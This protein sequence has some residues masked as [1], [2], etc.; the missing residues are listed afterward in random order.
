MRLIKS[1]DNV[2]D[3][4]RSNLGKYKQK[5]MATPSRNTGDKDKK[6]KYIAKA[7]A[8]L[9]ALHANAKLEFN[10]LVFQYVFNNLRKRKT[11]KTIS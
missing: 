11:S 9:F 5:P 4:L 1:L 6:K 3:V 10:S 2:K 7:I 8:N